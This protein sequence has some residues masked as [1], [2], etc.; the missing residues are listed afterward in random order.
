MNLP[1]PMVIRGEVQRELLS[2]YIP[3]LPLGCCVTFKELTRSLEQNARMWAMLTDVSKQTS[4]DGRKF[5][6]D[7]FKLIFMNEAG[8]D[9]TF[10]PQLKG[11][12]MFPAGYSSSA[13]TIRQMTVLMQSIQVYGDEQGVRW[14]G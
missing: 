3:W 10:L 6:K 4:L 7:Q 5:T 12:G 11:S 8:W 1:P 14:K 9:V 2:Q 13:L